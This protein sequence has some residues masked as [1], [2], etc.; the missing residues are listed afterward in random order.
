MAR[1]LG[2]LARSL[3]LRGETRSSNYGSSKRAILSVVNRGREQPGM[4]I[5][6]ETLFA[7]EKSYT[8]L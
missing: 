2:K 8:N 5:N 1:M 4:Y 3:L 6:I 7:D